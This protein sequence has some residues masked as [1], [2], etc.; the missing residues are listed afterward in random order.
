[1]KSEYFRIIYAKRCLHF[2]DSKN[3]F[4]MRTLKNV[5]DLREIVELSPIQMYQSCSSKFYSSSLFTHFAPTILHEPWGTDLLIDS[6]SF[7]TMRPPISSHWFD[8]PETY[9]WISRPDIKSINYWV[10]FGKK[11]RKWENRSKDFTTI[12]N[13]ISDLLSYH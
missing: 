12:S 10:I 5:Y 9:L 2:I 6:D 8:S 11:F 4:R 7:L 1:M 13:L 3:M